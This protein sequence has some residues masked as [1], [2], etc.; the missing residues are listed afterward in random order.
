M[1]TLFY[2]TFYRMLFEDFVGWDVFAF[3]QLFHFSAEW[4]MYVL[5]ATRIFYDFVKDTPYLGPLRGVFVMSGLSHRDWQI[6][7]S[8]DFA[9]RVA[10]TFYSVPVS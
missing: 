1:C 3:V 7:L 9:L 5:R 8:L 10:V 6:F 2:Y 4:C